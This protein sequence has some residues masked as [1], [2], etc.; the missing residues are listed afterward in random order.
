MDDEFELKGVRDDMVPRGALS[1]ARR[2]AKVATR[3]GTA[4]SAAP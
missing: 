1:L 3:Q 4:A 2:V